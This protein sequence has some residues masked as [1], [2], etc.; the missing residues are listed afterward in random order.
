MPEKKHPALDGGV[1]TFLSKLGSWCGCYSPVGDLSSPID[2]ALRN[3]T[4]AP[5]RGFLRC[6]SQQCD[7]SRAVC[8]LGRFLPKLGGASGH[9]LFL[10]EGRQKRHSTR[11]PVGSGSLLRRA[12]RI[13]HASASAGV[14]KPSIVCAPSCWTTSISNPSWSARA[15]IVKLAI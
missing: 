11:K 4:C 9:R 6:A 13:S 7:A 10:V 3:S 15:E 2:A 14:P 5:T 12:D 8:F 1:W